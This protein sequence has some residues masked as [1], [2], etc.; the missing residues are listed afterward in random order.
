MEPLLGTYGK[1][2][3]N[4]VE[5]LG[6]SKFEAGLEPA[7]EDFKMAGRLSTGKKY[8]GYEI[9]GNITYFKKAG[10]DPFSFVDFQN[11]SVRNPKIADL[12]YVLKDPQEGVVAYRFKNV[13]FAKV[14]I[15]N[16]EVGALVED[17]LEFT[18]DSYEPI[19][20]IKL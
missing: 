3:A 12:L 2:Y 6:V 13:Q 14:P 11:V 8:A 20:T 4:G 16:A 1:V 15:I 17:E 10:R 7:Y 9:G 5:W 19:Y 18:C